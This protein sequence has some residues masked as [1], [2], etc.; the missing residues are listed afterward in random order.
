MI[1]GYRPEKPSGSAN[2]PEQ[3]AP[4]PFDR[5]LLRK[6]RDR[7]AARFDEA[8][9]LVEHAAAEIRDRL[10]DV[11]RTFKTALDFG[12]HTGAM[13]RGLAA[14]GKVETLF[15][16]DASPAMARTSDFPCFVADEE[17]VPIAPESLD[18]VVSALTLHWVNDLPGALIQMRRALRPDGLFI[19]ALL[20]GATL[21]ELREVMI[22]AE[23][24]VTG[25]AA[26]RV[27]PFADVRTLG[28]LLQRA[29]LALPVVDCD[30]L[31]V[32]YD[33]LLGLASDIRRMG[34]ANALT[35]PGKPLR[36]DTL[37]RAGELYDERYADADGRIRAT[38]EIVYMTGWA[39]HES[40]QQPLR[41]GSARTRLADALGTSE[42]SA[43]EPAGPPSD[44]GS[45]KR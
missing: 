42:V 7:Y 6:R 25:G 3:T 1:D 11:K 2:A 40:Q 35:G 33:G 12:S 18:L 27:A 43:G 21:Q 5:A 45:G 20:G 39:P 22:A 28:S 44:D 37:M 34:A 36:R 15:S 29:G 16:C 41:P 23:A 30:R 31:T 24:E 14:S 8:G 32:R 4:G 9:F 17:L 10:E 26:P 13:S 19:A 38:F